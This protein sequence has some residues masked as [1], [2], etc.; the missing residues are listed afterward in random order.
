MGKRLVTIYHDIKELSKV[1]QRINQD[2][3]HHWWDALFGWSPSAMGI[4][5]RLCPSSIVILTLV[6]VSL[7]PCVAI[8]V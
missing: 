6:G 1:L 2:T 7:V 4:L 8:V 3:N 5:N